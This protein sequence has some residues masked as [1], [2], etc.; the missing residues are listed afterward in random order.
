MIKRIFLL[1]LIFIILPN[2]SALIINEIEINPTLG[3]AEKEWVEIYNEGEEINVSGWT[4]NDSLKKR[5]TFGNETFIPGNGYY[6]VEF[7]TATL[8]NDGDSLTL[9]N[10]L[11]EIID[12]TEILKEEKNSSKTWQL[13]NGEWEFIEATKEAK[14]DCPISEET[15]PEVNDSTNE[16]TE[17]NSSDEEPTN[18]RESKENA[19][20]ESIKNK[21]EKNITF[22][23]ISLVPKDIK[24]GNENSF[25]KNLPLYGFIAF[26]VFLAILFALKRFN[27]RLK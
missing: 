27:R 5:F 19:V 6:I 21:T 3:S 26:C 13:C 1:L 4:I 25:K 16:N 15:P 7:K 23:K 18:D 10:S 17:E 9:I 14:N 24:S 20:N 12:S 22:S 2:I 11:G 8:N